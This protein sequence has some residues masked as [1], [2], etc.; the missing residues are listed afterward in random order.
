[1]TLGKSS[2]VCGVIEKPFTL[3]LD[4]ARIILPQAL[5][6]GPADSGRMRAPVGCDEPA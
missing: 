5:E 1:M 3:H 4:Q 6:T 2:Y